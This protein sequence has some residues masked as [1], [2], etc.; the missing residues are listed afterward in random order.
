MPNKNES[1][2]KRVRS[3][4][5]DGQPNDPSMHGGAR[6]GDPAAKKKKDENKEAPIIERNVT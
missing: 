3:K 5:T 2:S 1:E 6:G 4:A